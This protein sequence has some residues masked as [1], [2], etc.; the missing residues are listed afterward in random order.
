MNFYFILTTKS[1]NAPL[2]FADSYFEQY[3]VIVAIYW[4]GS[5]KHLYSS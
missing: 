5:M 4:L 3:K 1:S 2:I